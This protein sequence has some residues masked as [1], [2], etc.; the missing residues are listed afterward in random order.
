MSRLIP[1][2]TNPRTRTPEHIAQ[3]SASMQGVDGGEKL[4]H[5]GGV[6]RTSKWVTLWPSLELKNRPGRPAVFYFGT[7]FAAAASPAC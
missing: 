1:R 7:F 2:M 5:F 4:G 3:F 6:K